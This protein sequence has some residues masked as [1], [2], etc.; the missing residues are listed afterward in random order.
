MNIFRKTII[1]GTLCLTIVFASG[2]SENINLEPEG[3]ITAEG[4]YKSEAD[5]DKALNALYDRF[6]YDNYAMWMDAVSD[7]ALVNHSWN[8]GYDLGRGLG[9]PNSTLST[10]KWNRDY[11]SIQR[12][13]TVINSID[14]FEWPGGETNS[15]RKKILGEAQTI[16]AFFYLDLVATYGRIMF[17]TTNPSTVEE[18]TKI[19]QVENPKVVFDFLLDDLKKAIEGLPEKASSKYKIGKPAARLLRARIASYAAGYLNDKVYFNTTLEETSVLVSSAPKLSEYNNLFISGCELI[20]EV[21]LVKGYSVDKPNRWGQW[22]NQSIKGYCLTVPVKSLVDSYEYIG[23]KN[24][25]MPYVNKDSRL[26]ASIYVPGM[27]LRNKYYNTIP[28]NVIQKDGKTYF[29]PQKDYGTLQDYDVSVG[30]ALGEGGGSEW[31]KT[32]S[33]FTWKK[34]CQEPAT[35][36]SFNSYIIFRYAEAY[37]LRAEALVETGGNISEAKQLIKVIRDRAG[38]T[39]EIDKVVTTLYNGSIRDLVRNEMRIEFA[40]EGL[41]FFDIRRWKILL[42]VMNKPV[43]GIEYYDYTNGT[44]VKRINKPAVRTEFTEKDF[45]WPIPQAEID[46]NKGRITQNAGWK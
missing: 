26:Y 21:I 18:S 33:G 25:K 19:K 1:Y 46:L 22:Y 30:D 9:N 4:Y 28:N 41:R 10:E 12:A 11:I 2:C 17:F 23:V 45:R 3:I 35:D 42:D 36:I 7:N 15:T 20:D 31:N 37:L 5:F 38:N 24:E 32:L 6:N 44:P 14:K 27:K 16:R 8:W 40:Q 13:N 29:D 39:N 43:E 34:Y